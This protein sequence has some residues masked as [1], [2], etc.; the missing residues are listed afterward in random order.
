MSASTVTG[1]PLI[2]LT[3]IVLLAYT[4]VSLDNAMLGLALPTIL[5]DTGWSVAAIGY[6]TTGGFAAAVVAGLVVGPLADRY[7]RRRAIQGVMLFTGVFSGLTAVVQSFTQFAAVRVLAGTALAEGPLGDA[8]LSEEAP[9]RRRGLLVGIAQAGNPLGNALAGVIAAFMLPSGWRALFLIAFLPA[10]FG[11]IAFQYVRDSARFREQAPATRVGSFGSY[12]QLLTRVNGPRFGWMCLF[13]FLAIGTYGIL[14][15]FGPLYMTENG[16]F[17]ASRA[18]AVFAAAQWAALI[19]QVGFGWLSDHVSPKW[20]MV[21]CVGMG[22][23]C[24]VVI[25]TSAG[26]SAAL[27]TGVIAATFF[28]QGTYGVVPRYLAESFPTAIRATVI[29]VGFG[30]AN[31]ALVLIPTLGGLLFAAGHSVSLMY[32]GAAFVGLA[33][34]IMAF[35]RNVTPGGIL[36]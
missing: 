30:L 20:T 6:V 26:S 3:A 23:L 11:V 34:V 4:F 9:P 19:S 28:V 32:I 36:T 7:G 21:F 8:L 16:G 24:M 35:A 27:V 18:A 2:I 29:S 17:T 14:L 12:R 15:I 33:A 22:A 25:A 13:M 31:L 5:K 1:R 10:V